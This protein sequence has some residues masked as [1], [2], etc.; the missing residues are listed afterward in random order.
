VPLLPAAGEQLD[1]RL[2]PA[3]LATW[4]VAWQG[5]LL[6]ADLLLAC[7]ALLAL[8]ALLLLGSRPA[9]RVLV[10]AAVCGCASASAW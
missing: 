2:V 7:G 3:A 4:L 8:A 5:R 10:G 9:Q 1:L 6:S